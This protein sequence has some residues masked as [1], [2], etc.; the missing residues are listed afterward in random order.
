MDINLGKLKLIE[1]IELP[2]T[3]ILGSAKMSVNRVVELAEGSMIEIERNIESSVDIS[4]SG[5]VIAKGEVVII[6]EKFGVR[7]IETCTANN[8]ISK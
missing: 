6:D 3:I 4:V 7:I 2:V 5:K 8:S 1:N